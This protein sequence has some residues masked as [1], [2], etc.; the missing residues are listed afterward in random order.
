[1]GVGEV[2]WKLR[3]RQTRQLAQKGVAQH[4]VALALDAAKHARL[5]LSRQLLKVERQVHILRH[6]PSVRHANVENPRRIVHQV[7][8]ADLFVV[9]VRGVG[10]VDAQLAA[11]V[12]RFRAVKAHGDA[13]HL[14]LPPRVLDAQVEVKWRARVV[15]LQLRHGLVAGWWILDG[16]AQTQQTHGGKRHPRGVEPRTECDNGNYDVRHQVQRRIANTPLQHPRAKQA[17]VCPHERVVPM[18]HVARKLDGEGGSQ[19]R[20]PQHGRAIVNG[21][22]VERRWKNPRAFQF[23]GEGSQQRK[24]HGLGGDAKGAARCES[25]ETPSDR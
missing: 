22:A 4:H 16:F 12:E 11:K 1:M 7:C 17:G 15:S 10:H 18:W 19:Q 3:L 25:D 21:Y 8:A 9:A 13:G 5:L 24:K 23:E 2:V 20:Q 6:L 14:E